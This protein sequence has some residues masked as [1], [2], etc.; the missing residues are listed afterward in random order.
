MKPMGTQC[1]PWSCKAPMDEEAGE[2][3]KI[4]IWVR[5]LLGASLGVFSSLVAA[6][7]GLE[8]RLRKVNMQ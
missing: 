6:D 3:W 2:I 1:A 8:E 5:Y 7:A 4:T